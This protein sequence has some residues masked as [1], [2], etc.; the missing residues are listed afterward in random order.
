MAD[1]APL[2]SQTSSIAATDGE[3]LMRFSRHQDENAFALLMDR[4]SGLVYRVCQT[5]LGEKNDADDAFQATFLVLVRHARK[6]EAYASIAGWLYKVALRTAVAARTKRGRKEQAIMT[7]PIEDSGAFSAIEQQELAFSLHEELAK[8]PE[9]YRTPL[10]LCYLNGKSRVEVA[11]QLDVTTQTIKA[12][13]ARGRAKLR[14]NLTRRG[15]AF[16]MSFAAGS[17]LFLHSQECPA[18]L[19]VET[20]ELCNSQSLA[21]TAT[22]PPETV[23]NLVNEGI[24]SMT[25]S[26]VGKTAAVVAVA[27]AAVTGT[28]TAQGP[29]SNGSNQSNGSRT[30]T[31]AEPDQLKSPTSGTPRAVNLV[32]TNAAGFQV[33]QQSTPLRPGPGV[34]IAA[35]NVGSPVDNQTSAYNLVRN[36]VGAVEG[37]RSIS[38][39]ARVAAVDAL[40]KALQDA[41]SD[42]RHSAAQALEVAGAGSAAAIQALGEVWERNHDDKLRAAAFKSLSA[43][44]RGSDDAIAVARRIIQS[45]QNPAIRNQAVAMLGMIGRGKDGAVVAVTQALADKDPKV[46]KIAAATLG[47]LVSSSTNR[48]DYMGFA[49]GLAPSDYSLPGTDSGNRNRDR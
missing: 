27:M 37:T 15:V 32:P 7:E 31:L 4:H 29:A 5:V 30:L 28:I 38:K 25:I 17:S 13:L 45:D 42:V 44:G 6:L 14:S 21:G 33:A 24:R 49:R 12:R 9:Q 48:R 26:Y 20:A 46:R 40:I 11:Q 23:T 43:I 39:E 47:K 1:T 2:H 36:P 34:D 35:P 8:L 16:S 41:E 19:L 18:Q 3:L 22:S 10:I